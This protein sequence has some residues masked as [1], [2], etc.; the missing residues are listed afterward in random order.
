MNI[1]RDKG[2]G[3][4]NA[5]VGLVTGLRAAIGWQLSHEDR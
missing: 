3:H 5:G 4:Q 1:E 2:A